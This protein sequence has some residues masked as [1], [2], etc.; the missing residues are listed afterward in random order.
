MKKH[1]DNASKWVNRGG[2][3]P[4]DYEEFNSWLEE[5]AGEVEKGQMASQTLSDLQDAFGE[6]L[7]PKTLQGI[8]L[9]KPRGYA[10]DFE[11]IDRVY[12]RSLTTDPDLIKWDN[13]FLNTRAAHAVRNRKA[14]FID[15]INSLVEHSDEDEI[16]ILNVASGPAR[17]VFEFFNQHNEGPN[18]EKRIQFDCVEFDDVAIL[19]AQTLCFE[20][21]EH[22]NF[23]KANAF[24]FTT[25][26]RFPLIWS[27]GLFDYLDDRRFIFLTKRLYEFVDEGGELVIGNF[28]DNNPSRPYMEVLM[29]WQLHHRGPEVLTQLAKDSGIP[30]SMIYIG[31]EPEG[32]NLFLHLKK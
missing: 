21:M 22:I 9:R 14:Y 5:I 20:F 15:L 25:E 31:K 30:E 8:S 29:D 11:V 3:S 19:Y 26:K 23:M 16:E 12:Q 2:P 32:I 18:R 6:A 28:S 17:D 13:F 24:R 1:I 27:A 7:S 10:G 4:T